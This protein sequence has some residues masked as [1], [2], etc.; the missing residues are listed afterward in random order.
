VATDKRNP[1]SREHDEAGDVLEAVRWIDDAPL[2]RII[3]DGPT[4]ADVHATR[5]TP[6]DE[7]ALARQAQHQRRVDEHW[8]EVREALHDCREKWGRGNCTLTETP[9]AEFGLVRDF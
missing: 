6:V 8:R 1:V 4:V 2:A 5:A 9:R 3:H 7:A